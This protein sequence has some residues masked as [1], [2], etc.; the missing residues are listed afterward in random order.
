MHE[1][2]EPAQRNPL[3]SRV[4]GAEAAAQAGGVLAGDG[5]ERR[6]HRALLRQPSAL[7]AAGALL[8]QQREQHRPRALPEG[9]VR[10]HGR[11][12]DR[13]HTKH[14]GRHRLVSHQP[15]ASPERRQR[16][17]AAVVPK[18]LAGAFRYQQQRSAHDDEAGRALMKTS[19]NNTRTPGKFR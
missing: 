1:C 19:F 17:A 4:A 9:H 14:S 16:R 7:G 12:E 8:A 2:H 6:H 13:F 3:R 10:R 11:I 18:W 15:V 5:D